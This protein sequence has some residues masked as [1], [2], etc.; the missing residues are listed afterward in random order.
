MGV[1]S[2]WV[3]RPTPIPIGTYC[4]RRA[5]AVAR[6]I[7]LVSCYKLVPSLAYAHDAP[8]SRV[9][10][11]SQIVLEDRCSSSPAHVTS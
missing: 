2:E 7:A 4:G 9:S 6:A 1:G 10:E 3:R 8:A 11:G 5:L